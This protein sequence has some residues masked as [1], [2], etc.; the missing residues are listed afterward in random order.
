MSLTPCPSKLPA[1]QRPFHEH[2]GNTGQSGLGNRTAEDTSGTATAPAPAESAQEVTQQA[3]LLMN[4]ARH[5]RK[6]VHIPKALPLTW[7]EP[8]KVGPPVPGLTR[9]HPA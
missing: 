9:Q 7:G 1:A 6:P 3:R 2:G 5:I 8:G 4:L